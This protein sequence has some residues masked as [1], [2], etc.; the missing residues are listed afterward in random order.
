M[1]KMSPSA[2]APPEATPSSTLELFSFEGCPYAQRVRMVLL[3][4]QLPCQLTEIDLLNRPAWFAAVSPYGKVPVLRH[5]A[6]TIYESGIITQYLDEAFP[7]QPLMPS[8]PVLRAQARIWM[9]Y[10]DSRLLPA[11][12]KLTNEAD[13][14]ARR[15]E[16]IARLSDV[17]RF[18]DAEGLQQH[19]PGPYFFGAAVSLV[20]VH[21]APFLERFE[22]YTR[23]G[24]AEIPAE[25]Q[26]LRLWMSAVAARP[27]ALATAKPVEYHLAL[28]EQ[29]MVRI[30]AARSSGGAQRTGT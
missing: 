10:C 17:L 29:M 18:L 7:D 8:S 23:L 27:S 21:F 19:G 28:R 5:G 13:D 26:R 4:K 11:A 12:Q 24:G 3:E 15:A 1:T 16:N 9:D 6:A 14:P 20:D 30:R 2:A 22:T 25:C